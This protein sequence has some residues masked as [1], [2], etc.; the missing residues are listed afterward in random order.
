VR[1]PLREVADLR[2]TVTAKAPASVPNQ[3]IG[4]AVNGT[5]VEPRPLPSEWTDVLF[6]VPARALH[7]GENVMCLDFAA[8]ARGPEAFRPAASVS[9]IQ[10]P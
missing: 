3:A 6:L 2:V 8:H 9:R 7:R 10:L 1:I 4:L 5:P